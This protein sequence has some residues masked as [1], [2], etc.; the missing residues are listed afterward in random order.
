MSNATA[1]E[2]TTRSGDEPVQT[3]RRRERGRLGRRSPYLR[4]TYRSEL[5][6]FPYSGARIAG[7]A[8]LVL[9]LVAFP[10]FAGSFWIGV[11]NLCA[12]TAI[13]ALGVQIVTGM[14]G[15]LSLG[16]AAFLAIGGFTAAGLHLHLELRV[17]GE[18]VDP[19]AYL[20]ERGVDLIVV[21]TAHGH[22]EAALRTVG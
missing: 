22:S 21:D 10:L 2:T 11:A 16:H 18:P 14:A 9:A 3:S 19:E 17:D 8:V 15:Q 7:L 20:A 5:A 1:S 12:I 13:A 4:T 6:F